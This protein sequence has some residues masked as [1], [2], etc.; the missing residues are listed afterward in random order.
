MRA[1]VMTSLVTVLAT[2]LSGCS[3]NSSARDRPDVLLCAAEALKASRNPSVSENDQSSLREKATVFE[4]KLPA[5]KHDDAHREVERLAD[6][7]SAA[8]LIEPATC[9]TLLT[10]DD[11]RRISASAT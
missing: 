11:R 10:P 6:A 8:P 5:A 7:G 1:L 2:A 9:E 3:E 4:Q